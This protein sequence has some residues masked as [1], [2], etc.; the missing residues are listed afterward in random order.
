[1]E[2]I[3]FFSEL[4]LLKGFKEFRF[5]YVV[6][7]FLFEDW[8]N[9]TILYDL[10]HIDETDKGWMMMFVCDRRTYVFGNNWSKKQLHHCLA[11]IK[12]SEDRG[13]ILIGDKELIEAVLEYRNIT[14]FKLLRKRVLYVK[15]I[16]NDTV[17]VNSEIVLAR[18]REI[19]I[20]TQ[21][22]LEF[23]EEVYQG[24]IVIDDRK[25][26]SIVQANVL[27]KNVHVLKKDGIIGFCCVFKNQ[28]TFLYV[29]KEC[30]RL[31]FGKCLLAHAAHSN[32]GK[33]RKIYLSTHD[34]C[35]AT[36]RT[37]LTTGFVP[38][39]EIISIQIDM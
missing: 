3:S 35:D 34:E 2:K 13:N 38:Y 10:S 19:G 20:L 17:Y 22:F 37:I 25:A 32:K 16:S 33:K 1:M 21:L 36:V 5:Q 12:A 29:K 18:P 30:R 24:K 9:D 15:R 39:H 31:G 4:G 26:E 23:H 14:K 11:S 7:Q 28:I 27:A 8:N 6:R